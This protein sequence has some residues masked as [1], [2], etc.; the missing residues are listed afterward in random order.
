MTAPE[1]PRISPAFL[2]GERRALP[3]AVYA[4]KYLCEFR[5]TDDQVFT[6]D[7]VAAMVTGKVAP[8]FQSG[9]PAP[10]AGGGVPPLYGGGA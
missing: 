5:E 4:Q 1:C 6:Y 3:E 8:L 10:G 2:E 9:G 7:Q